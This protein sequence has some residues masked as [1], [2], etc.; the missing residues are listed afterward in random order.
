MGKDFVQDSK[1]QADFIQEESNSNTEGEVDSN[2]P[3]TKE[4]LNNHSKDEWMDIF[5]NGQL[6]KK[7]LVK[8][9]HGT[10]PNR[11]DT[12]ILKIVGRIDTFKVVENL[13]SVVIQLGDLDVVQ[14]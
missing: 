6:R 11:G 7:V 8:G 14:V 4:S 9:E 13:D 3:V 1:T 2:N 5:G 12:C 10:R